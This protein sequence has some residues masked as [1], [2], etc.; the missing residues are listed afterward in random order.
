LKKSL[1]KILFENQDYLFKSHLDTKYRIDQLIH[2][3]FKKNIFNFQDI[4]NIPKNLRISLE[5]DFDILNFKLIKKNIS[6]DGTIKFLFELFD[7]NCIESVILKD[8]NNRI[9]FCISTQIG[10]K[11]NCKFCMT[12][13]M[14]FI[15]NLHYTEIISQIL[16]LSAIVD[17]NFNIVFM[18]MGEPLDNYDNL[19][20]CIKILTDKKFFSIS[21]SR[22]TVSTSGIIEGIKKITTD[23]PLINIS[24]SI[25]SL[26]KSTREELMPITKKNSIDKLISELHEIYNKNKKRITFEYVLIKDKNINIDEINEFKKIKNKNAFLIN[27]IPLNDINENDIKKP[28]EKEIKWFCNMLKENGFKVTRRYRRGEDINSACGQLYWE[29]K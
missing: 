28:N 8:K 4:T 3:I 25:N 15:R 5:N 20:K 1:L 11:M 7:K 10:C 26:I 2:S 16:F 21:I 12:G 17:N 23:F 18:G 22:I 29:H 6:K 14:G 13:K 9:T 19:Y 24:I 27:I